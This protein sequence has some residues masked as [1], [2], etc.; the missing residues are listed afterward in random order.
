MSSW[1]ARSGGRKRLSSGN[2]NAVDER[3]RVVRIAADLE[4]LRSTT[5]PL[6]AA[7]EPE[8]RI[9]AGLRERELAGFRI[10]CD[11]LHEAP[12]LAGGPACAR[13]TSAIGQL[14]PREESHAQR[15]R[16]RASSQGIRRARFRA[17]QPQGATLG[18]RPLRG[19][20][21]TRPWTSRWVRATAMIWVVSH[22][23]SSS[24]VICCRLSPEI[25]AASDCDRSPPG[26]RRRFRMRSAT[27]SAVITR[28]T[29]RETHTPPGLGS[30]GRS[31]A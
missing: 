28:P 25:R 5:M 27:S 3:V 16:A 6:L 9:L 14:K 22:V 24:A 19:A 2:D 29:P 26:R 7:L 21:S 12:E 1:Y 23:A 13:S 11:T 31:P 10:G 18:I 20:R 17:R 4:R 15:L 30:V 8:L